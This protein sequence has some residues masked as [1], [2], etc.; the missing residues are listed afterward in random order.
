MQRRVQVALKTPVKKEF[1]ASRF[2]WLMA[3]SPVHFLCN[4]L[5][6]KCLRA[7]G[8][9]PH[10]L[11]HFPNRFNRRLDNLY[12]FVAQPTSLELSSKDSGSHLT[13]NL[14]RSAPASTSSGMEG[15]KSGWPRRS[16]FNALAAP[17]HCLLSL[18]KSYWAAIGAKIMA[19]DSATSTGLRLDGCP[20]QPS[21]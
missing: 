19:L 13:A 7:P 1:G 18:K 9:R 14:I 16:L 17:T 11:N 4:A 5:K 2:Y 6:A 20:S 21:P 12:R 3:N 15:L 10:T 8:G